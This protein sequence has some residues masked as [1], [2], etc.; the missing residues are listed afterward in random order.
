[1]FTNEGPIFQQLAA[2]IADG[3]VNGTY[4]EETAVPSATDFAAFHRMNPATASKGVNTLVDLGVLYKKRGVGM[5]VASGAREILRAQRRDE[6][7]KKYLQPLLRET[8]VL[9]ITTGKLH[10]MIDDEGQD[11]R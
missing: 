8:A 10:S 4:L 2:M 5:F 11:P 9:G 7:R 3:I 6:F 1:M